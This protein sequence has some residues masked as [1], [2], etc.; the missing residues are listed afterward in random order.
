MPVR[1][2]RQYWRMF[3]NL[4]QYW[5]RISIGSSTSQKTLIP[6][7]GWKKMS[8]EHLIT[9]CNILPHASIITS[10]NACL[11]LCSYSRAPLSSY[12]S[13]TID[14]QLT[15]TLASMQLLLGLSIISCLLRHWCTIDLDACIC[16]V[17]LGL[18][19]HLM[20]LASSMHDWPY[21]CQEKRS[22]VSLAP[23]R[24]S[25]IINKNINKV[26][27]TQ[28]WAPMVN[29]MS[30]AEKEPLRLFFQHCRTLLHLRLPPLVQHH[31]KLLRHQLML[32]QLEQQQWMCSRC[33]T[34]E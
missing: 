5:H 18:L 17:T 8:S 13:C 31:F 25:W 28:D 21:V 33:S 2:L 9:Y 10:W 7:L 1:I 6:G 15:L 14:A 16:A 20:Y 4:C 34:L 27:P 11:H 23:Q 32:L 3:I 19:Y 24:L 12:V 29:H 30:L 26:M 22:L